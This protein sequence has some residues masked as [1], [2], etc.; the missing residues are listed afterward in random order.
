MR[1]SAIILML[2]YYITG[3]IVMPMGDFSCMLDVPKMYS[4][5]RLEDD[6]LNPVDF[7]FEHLLNLDDLEEHLKAAGTSQDKPHTPKY[8][9]TITPVFSVCATP[10]VLQWK[11]PSPSRRES[12]PLLSHDFIPS[13]YFSAVFRPPVA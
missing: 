7:V 9:H 13:G 8:T 6:D 4:E 1:R 10:L 3:T 11:Q 12:Y 5:C 2:C